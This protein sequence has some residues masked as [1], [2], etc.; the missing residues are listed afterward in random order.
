LANAA[1]PRRLVGVSQIAPG[2]R[3]ND[4]FTLVERIGA[5]GMS[6]VWR[7]TDELLGRPVAVKMLTAEIAADPGLREATWREA[8]AAARL[9]HPSVTRVYDYGEAVLP[10]GD[11]VAYLVMELVEG[12][13]LATRLAAGPL[14]WPEAA[15][16]GAHVAAALAAA[17]ELGVVHHDIKPANV[18]LTGDGAK[19][20]DFG[21]AAL[22]GAIDQDALAGTPS[23]TA[24]ER[25][26]WAP[27]Q[28]ASDIYS[29]GVLL[30]EA[31]TGEPPVTLA[32][33]TEAAAAH[34]GGGPRPVRLPAGLPAELGEL[35]RACQ[36]PDPGE[37]PP[38]RWVATALAGLA[39]I[40]DPGASVAAEPPTLVTPAVVGAAARP[41]PRT[42]IDQRPPEGVPGTA[43][44]GGRRLLV[45]GVAVA[46]VVLG[47]LVGMMVADPRADPSADPSGTADPSGSAGP[48]GG[49]GTPS[50]TGSPAGLLGDART[51][52]ADFDRVLN[53]AR[54]DGRLDR[55]PAR[56]LQDKLDDVIKELEKPEQA[57]RG[58]EKVRDKAEDLRE[59]IAE[60][61]AEGELP[62]ALASELQA[63]LAR[64]LR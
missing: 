45:A 17:H 63:L 27:A 32:S 39:G 12:Q 31:L 4:R 56:K 53:D 16:I 58:A 10:G 14:P 26:E 30:G 5:G 54:I 43:A 48:A 37:R 47:L 44:G 62:A 41:V 34:R 11:R 55:D 40:P 42:R 33:W 60:L 7:A 35:L 18:M 61:R 15:R 24:P 2:T 36:S 25:L 51:V 8:R 46:A 9:T 23:Y 57:A 6:Q 22:V 19:V 29:L 52:V 59:E 1:R 49:S 28:P 21:T 20:L 50:A 38:A 13:S 64:L 3:F